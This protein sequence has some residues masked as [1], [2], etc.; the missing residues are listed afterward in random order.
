MPFGLTN[1]PGG[2]QR[3]LNGI[4]SD[5][6][7][8]YVIIYLD[9]IL[10]FSGNKDNHFRH[11]SE[12]L[13][14]LRK[15]RLYA[16]GKKCDF[17]SKSID[18]LGH[19]IGPNG[20][21]IN[22]AKVKVIQDWPELRKVKDIQC[23]L[24]FANS[25]R[26]Y[27]HNYSDIVVPLICLTW[28]NISWNFD[29]SCKL[30]FLTLKQAFIFALVLTH[31]KPGC[32][33]VVETDASDYALAAILSQVK[34]NR[35][36]HP[37]T[38]LSHTF[39]DTKLNYNT[40]DKE[41]MAI[42]EAFKAW[43]HYLEGTKVPVDVVT[44][45][46]NLEYFCTTWILSRRQAQ[47][48]TF[49]SGFNM[50]IRFCPGCLRKKPNALTCQPDLYPKGKGKP[51]GTVNPQN[52]RPVFSSTQLSASLQATAMLLVA[53]HGIFTMDIEELQKDI[54]AA[55]DTDPA[56]QSFRAD[57]DNSKYLC[58]SVDNVGFVWIN[59]QILVPESR[60]LRLH[61]LQSFHDILVSTKLFQSFDG[62]ILGPIS[63]SL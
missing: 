50:V 63:E 16:N 46:K 6:L 1:V 25:Y 11:V 40:H 53:L 12:V 35:E 62:S 7:D 21:Q 8:I 27:I 13:K 43:R 39:S 34:S 2:F 47:W 51:Y 52:C 30:A 44:D 3:F 10:I 17:H 24:G 59:Q 49:L 9:N 19:M 41:L 57:S 42:Y 54:L 29:E 4:F 15:H 36:I 20:L 38:Y 33:L 28:K 37:V 61:V 45:H 55:Y 23:F 60:D 32:L 5:L 18:Y 26:Q 48:S 14:W 56:V 22:P 58:W 31:Y